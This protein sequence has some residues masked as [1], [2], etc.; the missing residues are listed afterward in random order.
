MSEAQHEILFIRRMYQL[1][2]NQN[3]RRRKKL[4]TLAKQCLAV[5]ALAIV[6]T[7]IIQLT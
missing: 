4:P 3:V 1:A 6:A 7:L 2:G 5:T